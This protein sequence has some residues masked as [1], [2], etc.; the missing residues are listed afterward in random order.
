MGYYNYINTIYY[1]NKKDEDNIEE[2]SF[3]KEAIN[4]DLID[5]LLDFSGKYHLNSYCD[6]R[7]Y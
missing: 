1:R 6:N 3:R 2:E 4:C 7:D 5:W